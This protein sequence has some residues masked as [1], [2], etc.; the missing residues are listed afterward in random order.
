MSQQTLSDKRKRGR[1][2]PIAQFA[3]GIDQEAV[4]ERIDRRSLAPQRDMEPGSR[5]LALNFVRSLR[6]TRGQDQ[7][8][9]DKVPPQSPKH[10]AQNFF[11]TGM[12]AS[13]ENHRAFFQS[14]T[15]ENIAR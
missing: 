8:K 4:E 10:F 7:K 12:R 3:R 15:G 1:A 2:V 6:V 9:I 5:Q 14:K 13:A 11:L